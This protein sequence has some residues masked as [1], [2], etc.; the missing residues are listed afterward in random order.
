MTPE[1]ERFI[2]RHEQMHAL[3][4]H[5]VRKDMLGRIIVGARIKFKSATR[6]G[7]RAVWR[8]VRRIDEHGR[9]EVRFHG[10][11]NFIVLPGEIMEVEKK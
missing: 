7:Y 4:A 3:F 10:W 11:S 8:T 6:S 1:Q 5:N 9:P 2:T